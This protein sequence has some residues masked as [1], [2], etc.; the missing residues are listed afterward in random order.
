[1]NLLKELEKR[2]L[3]LDG[4]W[5][6]TLRGL[7]VEINSC[8]EELNLS[9]PEAITKAHSLFA[10]A[11]AD[12]I[13]TNTSSATR[14]E[15]SEY[16]LEEK[17]REINEKA[18][19]LA[20]KAIGKK[21][22]VAASISSM[23]KLIEPLGELAFDEVF[24]AF[25]EQIRSCRK[26]DLILIETVSDLKEAKIAV[27]AAK[28]AAK[29]PVFCSMT[30][31]GERTTSGTD[32]KTF[33]SVMEALEVDGIG[34]NCSIPPQK[35]LPLVE[36]LTQLTS[37]PLIVYPNAG[38]PKLINGETCFPASPEE[39]ASCAERFYK[40]GANIIGGCCGNSPSH[41]KAIAEKVK[42]LPPIKRKKINYFP[43]LSSRTKTIEIFPDNSYIIG[44]SINPNSKKE[45]RAELKE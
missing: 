3:V 22:F 27:I 24:N 31:E 33:V 7:G 14:I 9:N 44:E 26:A 42:N 39:M 37:L 18:V 4:G 36:E 10:E 19:E 29:L 1:M 15:L 12:I 38:L 40:L 8:S 13:E 32:L 5:G 17:T 16:G 11:G 34:L 25:H 28:A 21:G 43:S 35:M 6:T 30:F 20:R 2:I 41:I 45:L 23:G